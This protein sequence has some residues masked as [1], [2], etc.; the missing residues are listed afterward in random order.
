MH[1]WVVMPNHVHILFQPAKGWEVRS[2]VA[3]WKK[4]TARGILASCAKSPLKM[5]VWHRE[6][7]DRYI[8][9][10][11]HYERARFYIEQNPVSAGLV[12][13]AEEWL[14]SSANPENRKL[15]KDKA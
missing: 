15:L 10:E 2:L 11:A 6:Y 12:T 3:S 5:Q 1:A 7:W 9:D 14:W 4:F 13:A 8:R